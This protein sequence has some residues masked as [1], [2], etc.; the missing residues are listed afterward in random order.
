METAQDAK[1]RPATS[2]RRSRSRRRRPARS[3]PAASRTRRPP[4]RWSRSRRPGPTRS[5]SAASIRSRAASPAAGKRFARQSGR[6]LPEDP[7]SL[8]CE[9]CSASSWQALRP[10]PPAPVRRSTKRWRAIARCCVVGPN[11]ALALT[12][13]TLIGRRRRRASPPR[14]AARGGDVPSFVLR[15]AARRGRGA[16]ARRH[17][18]GRRP[19]SRHA[20]APRGGPAI[21][22]PLSFDESSLSAPLG[23]GSHLRLGRAAPVGPVV[24]RQPDPRRRRPA[25]ARRSA[26]ARTSA[27]ASDRRCCRGSVPGSST[28]SPGRLIA[29]RR[30]ATPA[31]AR[32]PRPGRCRSRGLELAASRTMQWGGSGRPRVARFA[33]ARP[34][35][36]RQHRLR[37]CRT[38]TS[39]ATAWPG[40]TP[41]TP[42]S[43]ATPARRRSTA[44]RSARTRRDTCRA[45]TW[46]LI[47]VDTA[48]A[49][50]AATRASLRRARQHDDVGRGSARRS[51]AAPIAITSTST[52]TRSRASR[53]AIR[54]AATSGSNSIGVLVDSG[55]WSGTLMLHRGDAYPTAQLY[56]G[57]GRI[58]GVN[59]EV[60]W[61]VDAQRASRPGSGVLARSRFGD[62]TAPSSGGGSRCPASAQARYSLSPTRRS[63]R[64]RPA[65]SPRPGPRCR[66]RTDAAAC[67]RG[68]RRRAPARPSARLPPARRCARTG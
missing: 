9:A 21:R 31:P 63:R 11:G 34:A 35:R 59:G 33:D 37:R 23:V 13:I 44:R 53:S 12:P 45:T 67:R 49:V 39:P 30:T 8:A 25:G 15:A 22:Y 55:A 62:R 43:S 29:A 57:G 26:G 46:P 6:S 16:A 28:P 52:A 20:S 64:A 3:S 54:P 10:G 7:P 32:R 47:G 19:R 51:S 2:A 14:S 56:P 24:D 50:G 60:A 40:S 1:L 5:R 68:A 48:F 18:P 27:T 4:R 42:M 17:D 36:P 66:R 61:Q 65:R 41:A 58:S 38:A